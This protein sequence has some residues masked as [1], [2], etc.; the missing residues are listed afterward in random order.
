MALRRYSLLADGSWTGNL[1]ALQ[2]ASKDD[3][4]PK[5]STMCCESRLRFYVLRLQ[6]WS[7]LVC[8]KIAGHQR[9][10]YLAK[11]PEGYQGR[12]KLFEVLLTPSLGTD[13]LARSVEQRQIAQE[14]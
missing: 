8:L 12:A 9:K 1:S 14:V 11:V 2:V 10:W 7:L 5:V 13:K 4:V 3:G 6:N